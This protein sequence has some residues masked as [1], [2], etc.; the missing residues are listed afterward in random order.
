MIPVIAIFDIGKTNKKFFLIDE[1]YNI[2]MERSVPFDEISDEDG[3][4]CDDVNLL[5]QWVIETLT[6]VLGVKEFD[7]KAVNFSAYGASF[8][9]IGENGKVIAPLY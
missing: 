8:V 6:E 2:V 7:V 3:D 9:Y 4:A 1:T 5:T